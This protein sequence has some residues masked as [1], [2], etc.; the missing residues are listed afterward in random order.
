M[1]LYH[2]FSEHTR[3]LFIYHQYCWQCKSNGNGRGGL[4]LHHICGR[5][6]VANNMDSPLNASVLCKV[7][8]DHIGHTQKEQLEL[9]LYTWKVLQ[10]ERLFTPSD[11]DIIF[12][13]E[14]CEDEFGKSMQELIKLL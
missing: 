13:Q 10:V 3:S 8:H 1:K 12:L 5:R 4:E 7:C 6:K 9:M 2:P 14:Q 11:Y